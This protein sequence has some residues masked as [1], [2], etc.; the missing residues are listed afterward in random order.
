MSREFYACLARAGRWRFIPLQVSKGRLP[1]R[2]ADGIGSEDEKT[3][4]NHAIMLYLARHTLAFELDAVI[5][6]V[7]DECTLIA[8]VRR[9]Q[10]GIDIQEAV[11]AES[12][13]RL[14]TDHWAISAHQYAG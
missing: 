5:A 2:V 9:N 8:H 13:S 10:R 11:D 4:G 3:K 6:C 1:E 14:V 12:W 7:S